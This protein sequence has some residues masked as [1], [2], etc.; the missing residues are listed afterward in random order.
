MGTVMRVSQ[1]TARHSAALVLLAALA[2]GGCGGDGG[3]EGAPSNRSTAPSTGG[4]ALEPVVDQDFPDPDI[5]LVDGTYYAYATQPGDGSVNVQMAT[6]TDLKTW[7]VQ[8]QDPLPELPD[9]A[10]NGRTWAPEV[11]QGPDGYLMYMTARSKDPDL[12]CIGVATS[13]SPAGPF[14]PVGDDPLVCP[15]DEGGAIDAASY[16]EP[17]G[18]RYLLWKNDGNCCG[19][20]T[21]LHLQP[22]S[23][24]GLK[25][26]GPPV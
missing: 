12:Q 24:D 13:T 8:V 25:L 11:T 3:D 16:V 9:W 4:E 23:A 10:T 20:D 21:W 6:S 1:R 15:E 2:V 26:T 18:K 7:E 19:K 17:D 5:L 22:L 14:H